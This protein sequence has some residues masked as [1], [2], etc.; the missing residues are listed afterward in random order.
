[1]NESV[2]ITMEVSLIGLVRYNMSSLISINGPSFS[3][4]TY[5]S[6]ILTSYLMKYIGLTISNVSFESVYDNKKS[7]G[8]MLLS[9]REL[10]Q[11]KLDKFDIVIAESTIVTFHNTHNNLHYICWP[12]LSHHIE[13]YN[14]YK[15][16]FG[17]YDAVRR[18]HWD[19]VDKMRKDF[20]SLFKYNIDTDII[21]NMSEESIAKCCEETVNYV[22]DK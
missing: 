20:K 15:L 18:S 2:L 14:K 5:F 10:V 4:K 11:R 21:V 1:M 3:G 17:A 7:F 9:F 8:E 6:N 22:G 19:D 16:E 12:D 13:N